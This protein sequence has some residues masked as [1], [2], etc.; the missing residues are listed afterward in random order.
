MKK[1]YKLINRHTLANERVMFK[2][3]NKTTRDKYKLITKE[4]RGQY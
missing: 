4:K 1:N 2:K 3:N